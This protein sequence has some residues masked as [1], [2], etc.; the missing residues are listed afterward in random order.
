[1]HGCYIMHLNMM[2]KTLKKLL[3]SY[4]DKY[5]SAS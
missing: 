5:I 1:M 3:D 4:L 2:N